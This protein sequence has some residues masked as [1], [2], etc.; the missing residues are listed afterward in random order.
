MQELEESACHMCCDNSKTT[1]HGTR[2]LQPCWGAT[3]RSIHSVEVAVCTFA[4][5]SP[6][7]SH[8]ATKRGCESGRHVVTRLNKH[9]HREGK[10]CR[11]A[12][13]CVPR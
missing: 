10:G 6:H 4:G 2:V 7:L 3:D 8:S 9:R 12:Y 11:G 13:R 5:L 1:M